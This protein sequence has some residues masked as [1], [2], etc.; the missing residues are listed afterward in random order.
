MTCSAFSFSFCFSSSASRRSSASS[1]PRGRVPAMG[2]VMTC[3][4]STRTSISGD[5]PTMDSPPM[6]MKY[7]YGEGFTCRR[8][9]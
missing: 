7:M 5:E 1:R 9:R 8:A 4:P 3:R 6:R 2:W